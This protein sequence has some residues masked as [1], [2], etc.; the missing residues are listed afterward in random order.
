MASSPGDWGNNIQVTVAQSNAKAAARYAPIGLLPSDLYDVTIKYWPTPAQYSSYVTESIT[1][2]TVKPGSRRIDAVLEQN[3]RYLRLAY[4]TFPTALSAG[5]TDTPTAVASAQAAFAG[6]TAQTSTNVFADG[7]DSDPLQYDDY[8]NVTT[9]YQAVL[10][11]AKI[12]NI[13]VL[14]PDNFADYVDTRLLSDAASYCLSNLAFY[15]IEPFANS[16]PNDSTITPWS[17]YAAQGLISSIDISQL[18]VTGP[19]SEFAAIY[20]PPAKFPGSPSP[21]PISGI[22]AGIYAYTDATRGVWKA[23]AGLNAAIPGTTGLTVGMD[24]TDRDALN[25]QGINALRDIPNVGTVVWGARTMNGADVISSDYKYVPVRRLTSYIEASL[26]NG[27]QWA[28]FEPNDE[29][30]WSRLRLSIGTFMNGLFTQG[31]FSGT[32]A[33]DAYFV[34][35]D[36]TTTTPADQAAGVVNVVIGFAPVKPAEFI[37]LYLQQT[38]ASSS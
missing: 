1:C 21:Y 31:A 37:I 23:P 3:S 16:A 28:V 14:P 25:S 7:Q 29:T 5:A 30:L 33:K 13:L 6:G 17:S 32:S 19:E 27:I 24:G 11:L 8:S 34:Q 9:G 18:G 35:C 10:K 20:F 22:L 26:S 38:T 15:I 4:D 2:V 36:A 12:F